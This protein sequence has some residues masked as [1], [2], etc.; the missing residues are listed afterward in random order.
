NAR[1]V[2]EE[3]LFTECNGEIEI[4]SNKSCENTYRRNTFVDCEGTLTLRHG[5]RNQVEGN[6][7]FGHGKPKTGGVRII[8]EDQR[9]VNNYFADLAGEGTYAALCLM[10][11][12]PNSPLAGYDQIKRAVVAFNTVVNCRQSVVVGYQSPTR[13]EASLAPQDCTFAHNIIVASAAPLVRLMTAPAQFTWR[14]NFFFGAEPGVRDELRADTIDPHLVQQRDGRWRPA[15]D[16]P[17][18]GAASGSFPEVT[19]DIDG[20]SRAAKKDAGCDQQSTDPIVF[21]PMT[22]ADVGP[23]WR[24]IADRR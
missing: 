7:F 21:R 6:F 5:H 11:G 10:N 1:C 22:E 24:R 16:S 15:A 2:V 14:G 19:V 9:V 8:N 3:N 17:V 4:I 23:A 13:A 12:I 18:V 20:Q